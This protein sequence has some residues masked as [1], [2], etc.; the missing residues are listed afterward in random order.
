MIRKIITLLFGF[1]LITNTAFAETIN[2][3]EET[4]RINYTFSYLNVPVKKKFLPATGHLII[5]EKNQDLIFLKGLDL[6]VKFTSKSKVFKKAIDYDKYPNFRF[7]TS[8]ENPIPLI[9]NK[10]IELEGYL[11]FHG[12]TEKIKIELQN[13]K[14]ED[15]IAL[16]GFFN[17][18][19]TD[20]GIK[21]P[22]VFFIVLDDV[23]KA[24]VELGTDSTSSTN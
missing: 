13:K 24:K 14:N 4:S 19:M 8:L 10:A 20:F 1:C 23:I 7:W 22:R 18:K 12:V 16:I 3:N 21:P 9:S 6:D 11:S 5:E 15:G 2:F 17:I